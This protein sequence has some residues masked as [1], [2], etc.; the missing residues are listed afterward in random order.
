MLRELCL[1]QIRLYLRS[2]RALVAS[3]ATPPLLMVMLA[4][5][6]DHQAEPGYH[7]RLVAAMATLGI[8]STCYTTF[9]A[10]LVAS[11]D[12]GVLKRLRATPLPLWQHI[13]GRVAATVLVASAQ[14]VVLVLMGLALYGAWLPGFAWAVPGAVTVSLIGVA[15]AQVVPRGDA[16]AT[17]LST[18][19]LPV[20]LVSG[21]FFPAAELPGWVGVVSQASPLTHAGA[22]LNA[23]SWVDLAWLLA[24][25]CAAF[26]FALWRFRVEPAPPRA[27]GR[28]RL[29]G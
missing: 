1:Y 18:T 12:A 27:T 6:S 28:V 16:A 4:A 21:V 9:A 29:A 14:T 8:A 24:W 22:L 3:A 7:A 19:L 23:F 26:V 25:S 20:V 5:I 10:S 17:L 2:P 11:R 13:A 15:V